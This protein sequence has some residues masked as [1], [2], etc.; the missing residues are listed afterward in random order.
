MFKRIYNRIYENP[1]ILLMS[2]IVI[3]TVLLFIYLGGIILFKSKKPKHVPATMPDT[4][5]KQ[6]HSS[7]TEPEPQT[8]P[9]AGV[10]E[11]PENPQ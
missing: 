8:I 4:S 3:S 9:S 6:P 10:A 1:K 5:L 11:L 7:Q 2:T